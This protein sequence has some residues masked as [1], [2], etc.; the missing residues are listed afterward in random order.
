MTAF[1]AVAATELDRTP[2]GEARIPRDQIAAIIAEYKYLAESLASQFGDIY[3]TFTPEGHLFLFESPDAALQ[4][5]FKLIDSWKNHGPNVLG[6]ANSPHIPIRFGCHY[7]EC[8]EIPAGEGWLGSAIEL[9]RPVAV[10]AESDTVCVT[11]N[12][13]DLVDLTSYQFEDAGTQ[14]LK[15]DHL[16]RRI[17]YKVTAFNQEATPFRPTDSLTAEDWLLKAVALIGTDKENTVEEAQ[18][19]GQ[20][21]SLRADFPEAHNNLGAVLR[22]A[23][24]GAKAAEHYREA[25]RLRPNYPEAHYNYGVLLQL[26]GSTSGAAEHYREALRLRPDYVDAHYAYANL[27]V[28][29]G[30]L[31]Q[32]EE[33]YREALR[34]RPEYAEVHNNYAILLEEKGETEGALNHYREALRIRPEYAEAHYNYAIA[35]ENDGNFE[36]AESEYNEALRLR[37][38]YP[39]ARNNLAIMLQTRGDLSGA[40]GHYLEVLRQRPDDP[41]THYNFGLLL[42]AKGDATGAEDHFRTA[43][44]LAPPDWLVGIVAGSGT[45]TGGLTPLDSV[46][47]TQR[48]LEVLRLIA[49]GKSNRVIAQE[50]IISLSTVAHHVT[51]I[52]NKTGTSNRTEAV[53]FAVRHGLVER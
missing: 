34:L 20:A 18:F 21:L 22:I 52:L 23:G 47:L 24:D 19:Y 49:V 51:N 50:L 37:T 7:G 45:Q 27:L 44:D 39:E 36:E 33:Y 31:S 48:E 9:A 53:A 43:Y 29:A 16:P 28:T 13:L 5:G 4:F 12:I 35:L 8:T 30:E 26:R 17:L 2:L 42:K 25:L 46:A 40:E 41:E 38:D 15:G 14:E 1:L 10:A 6:L 3:R 32:A 11:G